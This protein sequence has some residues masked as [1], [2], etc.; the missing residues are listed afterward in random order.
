[1][2]PQFTGRIKVDYGQNFDQMVSA[3][4]Y[5]WVSGDVAAEYFASRDSGVVECEARLFH[6][7]RMGSSEDVVRNIRQ[8]DARHPWTPAKWEH[9]LALGA[10]YPDEQTKSP[11]PGLGS[12]VLIRGKCGVICLYG[13]GTKRNVRVDPWDG[14]W[15]LSFGFLAVR[16]LA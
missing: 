10:Q 12:V 2:D 15:A 13:G 9:V 16:K 3:G 4:N 5:T 7:D 6:F 1:M 8:A 14:D 11:I